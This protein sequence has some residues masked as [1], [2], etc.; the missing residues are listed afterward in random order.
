M[1]QSLL[2]EAQ[3]QLLRDEKTALA[4]I[5]LAP[6]RPP[7]RNVRELEERTQDGVLQATVPRAPRDRAYSIEGVGL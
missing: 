4:E 3:A 2:T 1:L 5:R 7:A 6:S